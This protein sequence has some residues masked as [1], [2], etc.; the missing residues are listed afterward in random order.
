MNSYWKGL[1]NALMITG[2]FWVFMGLSLF[3]D[4]K[5]VGNS[6]NVGIGFLIGVVGGY[7][8]LQVGFWIYEKWGIK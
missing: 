7:L 5:V 3:I 4:T 6:S 1:V 8:A 2:P